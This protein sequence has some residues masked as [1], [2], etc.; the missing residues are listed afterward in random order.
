MRRIA[1]LVVPPVFAYDLSITQM[2][3][4]AAEVDG[5]PAYRVTT[6]TARPGRVEAVGGPDVLIPDDLAGLDGLT[7][8]DTVIVVGGGAR[9]DVDPAV[10]D[11]VRRSADAGRRTAGIC[12]GAFVL[13]HA[14]LLDGRRATTHWG[15]TDQLARR[16]PAVT[17][18]PHALHVADGP[19][20]TSAG[21]A[22]AIE[23]CL[24][25][26][27][28]DHGS[29]VAAAAGQLAVVGPP[30]PGDQ[31]QIVETPLPPVSVEKRSLADTR[32]WALRR[33]D[34]PLTLADLAAHAGVST[35]T[36]TRRFHAETG[37]SPL[38]WLLHQRVDRAR[39]LLETTDLPMDR[40]AHHSG[41][42][43]ADSLRQHL[44]RA[45]GVTPSAYRAAAR[46]TRVTVGR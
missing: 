29:A 39:Q 15:L 8:A 20:L 33:L 13:G 5:R 23:L 31:P 1:F 18:E 43:S 17:V 9:E 30:R 25:I 44:V 28:T 2:L 7:A 37:L 27:R 45:L 6:H 22:A 42:G 11:A 14:G 26:I 10:L 19:I 34:R 16:F 4:G 35:R 36:L 40:V 46:E 24:H 38:R 21:A 41:L 32:A 3:L 12:T